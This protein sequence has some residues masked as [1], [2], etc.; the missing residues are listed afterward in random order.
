MLV[1]TLNCLPRI[2]KR[3]SEIRTWRQARS[4]AVLAADAERAYSP[5]V[6]VKHGFCTSDNDLAR[7]ILKDG[8]ADASD[9]T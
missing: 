7:I 8:T 5:R 3:V 4:W 1:A 6:L 2:F 9:G